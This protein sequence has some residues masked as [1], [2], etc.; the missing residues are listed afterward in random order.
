[1]AVGVSWTQQAPPIHVITKTCLLVFV[2]VK[3][4]IKK[5]RQLQNARCDK[6]PSRGRKNNNWNFARIKT[7]SGVGPNKR[8]QLVSINV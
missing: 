7:V 5:F 4:V 6:V 2:F 1:M 8:I 3:N